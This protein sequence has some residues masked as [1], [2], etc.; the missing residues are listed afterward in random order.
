MG[1]ETEA[2]ILTKLTRTRGGTRAAA[3][4]RMNRLDERFADQV[5]TETKLELVALC[6]L[7][8]KHRQTLDRMNLEIQGLTNIDDIDGG[9][10]SSEDYDAK[11]EL[12]IRATTKLA[13]DGSSTTMTSNNSSGDNQDSRLK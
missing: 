2:Q 11:I 7:L 5:D 8:K 1:D 12:A 13:T 10:A 9:F 4:K 6:N 3:T